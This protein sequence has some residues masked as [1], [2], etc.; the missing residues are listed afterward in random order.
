M[1]MRPRLW[2]LHGLTIETGHDR[3]LIAKRLATVKPDGKV[4]KEDGW[5]LRTYLAAAGQVSQYE[6]E[7]ARY[8]KL[9]ADALALEAAVRAGEL[10]PIG[11]VSEARQLQ[12]KL[13]SNH[14]MRLPAALPPL[15]IGQSATRMQ[16][17]LKDVICEAL[18][19]ISDCEVRV[20]AARVGS[21]VEQPGDSRGVG[22]RAQEG[23]PA[24]DADGERVG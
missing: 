11:P 24:A 6:A 14:L 15:L 19:Q 5:L 21:A 13:M 18:Q 2:T 20:P 7:R 9:K 17:I 1:A 12:F 10:A 22:V 4:G 16:S 3:L 23:E 8:M